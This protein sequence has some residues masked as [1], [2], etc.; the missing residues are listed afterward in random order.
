MLKNKTFD[1]PKSKSKKNIKMNR[2]FDIEIDNI[3]SSSKK[4]NW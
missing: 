3:I 1:P 2:R 4:S